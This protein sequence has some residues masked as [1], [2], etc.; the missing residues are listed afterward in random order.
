V[1]PTFEYSPA[2]PHGALQSAFADVY[3]VLGTNKTHHAG[4]DF[5][6]S[7][8]MVVLRED[9]ALTLIN[10]VRLTDQALAELETLG[11]VRNVVR[12]GA[13]HGRDDPFYRDRYG[14]T[15]WAMPG[16]RCV[17]GRPPDAELTPNEPLPA[18]GGK[19][20]IFASAAHPE[21]AV[22]L[23]QEGGILLT[24]DAVQNWTHVDPFFS[25]ETGDSFSR[26][27][28]I[29]A[30]NIPSTWLGAC[31]PDVAD[32]EKLL[33]LPFRHLIS[34]HGEPLRDDARSVLEQSLVNAFGGLI[35][36]Q[37]RRYH[38]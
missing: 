7:R 4:I 35:P 36:A 2:W 22:V 21:A 5:Q 19:V 38:P 13:F 16:V 17:D 20:V 18:H 10:T 12:L 14:A 25:K 33:S 32:Y 29:G 15:I 6:T 8:T 28:L 30:A 3:F 1:S 9:D 27:G 24:C 11:R 37:A 23:P 26:Q 31:R 34:A